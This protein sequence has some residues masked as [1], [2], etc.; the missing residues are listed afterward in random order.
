MSISNKIASQ[1]FRPIKT[2]VLVKPKG[3]LEEMEQI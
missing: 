1:P 3:L 2:K